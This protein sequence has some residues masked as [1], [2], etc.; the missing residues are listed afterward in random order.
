MVN[1]F[2]RKWYA[3]HKKDLKKYIKYFKVSDKPLKKMT[4]EELRKYYKLKIKIWE[5]VT[6]RTEDKSDEMIDIMT[7]V[8][9]LKEIKYYE[10]NGNGVGIEWLVNVI[11]S[12]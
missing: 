4:L 5:I 7:K 11:E 1:P 6:S 8:D 12:L 9:I 10:E 3:K 2:F